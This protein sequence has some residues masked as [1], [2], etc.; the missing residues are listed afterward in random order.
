M[1]RFSRIFFRDFGVVRTVLRRVSDGSGSLGPARSS[2]E[3]IAT[4]EE[5]LRRNA[6]LDKVLDE[7]RRDSG[8]ICLATGK[9]VG[10]RV[11][12]PLPTM[13]TDAHSSA[14]IVH[15]DPA[16]AAAERDRLARLQLR[17]TVETKHLYVQRGI[18]H[19]IP[20]TLKIS[21]SPSPDAESSIGPV[22]E[23]ILDEEFAVVD[24]VLNCF[25]PQSEVSAVN[26]LPANEPHRMSEVLAV[27]MT[28][29]WEVYT[30]S[31]GSFDP[32]LA[33]AAEYCAQVALGKTP[34]SEKQRDEVLA[35]SSLA[36]GFRLD[37]SAGTVT[38]T[39]AGARLDLGALNKGY[40]VD[41]VVERLVAAKYADCFFEWGGDC[42]GSG[43]NPK[44][45]PWAVG[46]VRPPPLAELSPSQR[47]KDPPLIR[48]VHLEDEAMA[49]SGDYEH[50]VVV[51][52]PTF[53]STI[54]D[55]RQ[56]GLIEASAGDV[57]QVSVRCYCCMYADALATAALAKRSLTRIRALLDSWR[58]CKHAVT[59]YTAFVRA[60]ERVARM[61]EVARESEEMRQSRIST[62]IPARIIVVG[63]GL[64]GLSAAIEAANC[65]AH[66]ILLEKTAALGGNSAKATSG[67]NGWGT[68][69]QAEA[70]V[71]D[72]GKFFERDTHRSGVGGMTNV[73]NVRMLSVKSAE[74]IRWLQGFDIP[75]TVLSQLGG[76]SR[77]RTHRAPD[78][79]DGT[80]CPIGRTIMKAL[81]Q[82]IR[83]HLEHNITILLNS[84]VAELVRETNHL[85]DKTVVTRVRGVIA[86]SPDKQRLELHA[87]AVI[88]ATG[89]FSSDHADSSLMREF[90][91]QLFGFPTTNGL[92]AT[93][94][95]V[96][97]ARA[98]GAMLVDMDK[99][100]LH[101]TG[102]IDPKDP[103]NPTKFLG[104]EALRGSGGLLLN[105]R[106]ERFVNEL[107]LRSVVSNA[108]LEQ[109]LQY[110]GSNC[111]YAFCVLNDAAAKLFGR[112]SLEFYWKKAG[113]FTLCA[114]I[115]DLARH[116]GCSVDALAT[117][118]TEYE[119]LSTSRRV[120][121]L[122][123][124]TVYPAV[125]GPQ[126]P[127]YV[128]AVT[129]S[130]HYTMGGCFISPTAEVQSALQPATLF[131]SPRPIEGLFAAGEVSGGVHGANRLGGNSLLECAIFGRIAGDRAATILQQS[132]VA[133]SATAWAT[134]VVREVREGEAFGT[135]SRVI[136][137]SLPGA[138]QTSGLEIGQYVAVRGE[139]DGQVL[140]GFYS[141]IT[142]PND[143][144][145]IGILAR[146]DKGHMKEWLSAL[147]PG[148]AVQMR[149]CGGLTIKQVPGLRQLQFHGSSIRQ[150]GLIAGGSGIAPMIQILRAALKPP[151]AE[152]IQSVR[153]V[154][155]AEDLSEVTYRNVL[156]EYKERFGEKFDYRLVLNTPPSGWVHGVGYIDRPMLATGIPP[157]SK[158]LLICVCGPPAMQS[159]VRAMLLELGHHPS[160]VH[161]ID[162]VDSPLGIS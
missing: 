77:R 145:V 1:R 87:D 39:H 45:R 82:H 13:D 5:G 106:G 66:V 53:L 113:L 159:A 36:D 8:D 160:R 89:G 44:E 134:V 78:R 74:A 140:Q 68:R 59:D 131:G 54:F 104:P 61:H 47:P 99:V 122:T 63:G 98:A 14:S 6:A 48:V 118:L 147:C 130:I 129:P 157:P 25:N 18:R 57:A 34:W 155:A 69:A 93:G 16:L 109:G 153:V 149:S 95:G 138:L 105:S 72:H 43:K 32:A 132:A 120:C 152:S 84:S 71:T 2:C 23:K 41:R 46:I 50:P 85:H 4:S 10:E 37:F 81:E 158:D 151:Y 83:P 51:A 60:G 135:G 117:T 121:P 108:I 11:N 92:F 62:A 76:H 144:G 31:G 90:A 123:S 20:F 21:H 73:G 35:Y 139:W 111:R 107:D 70:G 17:D 94:D 22:V 26:A 91:P 100:Q 141:P 33:P 64:A 15:I 112:N 162:G 148:D 142:D 154:Y 40:T 49:T 80:P 102:F 110:P 133:L 114:T 12:A 24:A 27:V 28:C 119:A 126:G 9:H 124:K 161:S 3:S 88:L 150:F 86:N 127:F 30:S 58:Y 128:A 29:A 52:A 79:S 65:G 156:D 125:V 101:P 38:K 42:R 137:F 96:R 115:E 55:R 7:V 143:I 146:V 136:L 116:L 75:L 67:I 19:G 103:A 97:M 56:K